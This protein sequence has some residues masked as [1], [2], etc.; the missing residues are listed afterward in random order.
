MQD[1]AFALCNDR[2]PRGRHLPVAAR[3]RI[4][5][6][7]VATI[8][9]IGCSSPESSGQRSSGNT[10]SAEHL[11][12]EFAANPIDASARYRGNNVSV[13]GLIGQILPMDRG[14]AAVHLVDGGT[15]VAIA[16]IPRQ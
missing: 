10:L 4:T 7:I 15:R 11:Y 8:A 13:S 12:R 3:R 16:I 5:W 14:E 9:G 2:G 6:S 1:E